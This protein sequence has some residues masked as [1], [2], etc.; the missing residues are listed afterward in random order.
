MQGTARSHHDATLTLWRAGSSEAHRQSCW[1]G[2]RA[3]TTNMATNRSRGGLTP[4]RPPHATVWPRSTAPQPRRAHARC[5]ANASY[6][7]RCLQCPAAPFELRCQLANVL[8]PRISQ[9]VQ[10]MRLSACATRPADSS[11]MRRAEAIGSRRAAGSTL[12]AIHDSTR[13][14]LSSTRSVRKNRSH[15][16]HQ[17]DHCRNS[18]SPQVSRMSRSGSGHKALAVPSALGHRRWPPRQHATAPQGPTQTASRHQ[19]AWPLRLQRNR[20]EP[21]CQ[22]AQLRHH[23]EVCHPM[24]RFDQQGKGQENAKDVNPPKRRRRRHR[25]SEPTQQS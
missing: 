6:A 22:M 20:S 5:C 15:C 12:S 11:T 7:S 3:R 19:T 10:D 2:P 13:P 4:P 9:V 21:R 24:C 14:P 17:V 8:P 25:R 1:K 16:A 23:Q 18:A